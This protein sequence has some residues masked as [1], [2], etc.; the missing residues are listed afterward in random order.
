VQE[1]L[2]ESAQRPPFLDFL[3]RVRVVLLDGAIG[4]AFYD[5]GFYLNQCYD[6]LNLSAARIVSEVHEA[7]AKAGAQV[8]PTATSSPSTVSK[9]ICSKSIAWVP[10]WHVRPRA[11]V[12]SLP[13]VSDRSGCASSP[14]DPPARMKRG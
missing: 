8:M 2:D 4:T 14:S 7:Y 3:E 9:T 12:D 5:R 11:L 13:A 6:A 10:S 1:T